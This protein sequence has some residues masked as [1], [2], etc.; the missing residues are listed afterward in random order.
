MSNDYSVRR[1]APSTFP[2]A[3][4]GS[5]GVVPYYLDD[6]FADWAPSRYRW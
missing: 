2:A 5:R 1:S 4:P 6:H 3:L